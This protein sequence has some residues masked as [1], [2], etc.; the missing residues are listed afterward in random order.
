MRHFSSFLEGFRYAWADIST[1]C[2]YGLRKITYSQQRQYDFVI[3]LIGTCL[4]TGLLRN[5]ENTGWKLQKCHIKLLFLGMFSRHLT[6]LI[7]LPCTQPREQLRNM[8]SCWSSWEHSR[9]RRLL[10]KIELQQHNYRSIVFQKI[11]Q[12]FINWG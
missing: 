4:I 7:P 2:F 8:K 6:P 9:M 1:L 3:V 12:I 11:V 10:F 5:I